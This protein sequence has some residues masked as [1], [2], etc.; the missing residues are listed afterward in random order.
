MELPEHHDHAPAVLV[1]GGRPS[2]GSFAGAIGRANLIDMDRPGLA[3]RLR[4]LNLKQWQHYAVATPSLYVSLAIFDSRRVGV[5]TAVVYDR[6]SKRLVTWEERFLPGRVEFPQGLERGRVVFERGSLRIEFRNRLAEGLHQISF[7][8]VGDRLRPAVSGEVEVREGAG[9]QPLVVCLPLPP[10]GAMYSHKGVLPA[11]GTIQV[12]P[13]T[14][15]VTPQDS[16]GLPDIHQ[17]YY[18]REMAWRWATAGVV[19]DGALLGFNLT[20]NQVEDQERYNENAVWIGQRRVR[21]PA[22]RFEH[23]SEDPMA[24]WR[25][26]DRAGDGVVDLAFEPE[27]VRKIDLRLGPLRSR[28]RAPFG[29]FCGHIR[30][31]DETV[32]LDGAFGMTEDFYL[33]T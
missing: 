7:R 4:G 5:A 16:Y 14:H 33:R 17:G 19:R 10:S 2:F 21:L 26:R 30:A 24:P 8:C 27:V 9:A 18:P 20:D 29:A 6:A 31:G 32:D 11:S 1:E 13:D 23:D 25:V 3:G 28:Y 12:G 15:R 22:V